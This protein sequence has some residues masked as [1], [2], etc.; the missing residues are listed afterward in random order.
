M[1]EPVYMG[2]PGGPVLK[3]PSASA[4]DVGWIPGPGRSLEKEMATR[5]CIL[6]W[7]I[8]LTRSLWIT[9]PW[10]RTSQTQLSD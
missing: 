5:S 9:V 8:P 3:N 4:E 2:S 1:M 7:E 6:A 10:G